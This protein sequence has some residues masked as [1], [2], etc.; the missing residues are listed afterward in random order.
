MPRWLPHGLVLLILGA[1]VTAAVSAACAA[2][3]GREQHY[4]NIYAD[5][6]DPP[7]LSAFEERWV[8]RRPI[9][10]DHQ[11]TVGELRS[12]GYERRE[13]FMIPVEFGSI[14]G[15]ATDSA[16]TRSGW[17]WLATQCFELHGYDTVTYESA[18][19]IMVQF[20]MGGPI[21]LP[22]PIPYEPLWIGFAANSCFFAVALWLIWIAP[23]FAVRVVRIRN[24]R[25]P[26]CSY[27]RGTSVRCPECGQSHERLLRRTT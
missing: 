26:R 6:S 22:R 13:Y 19:P 27:P 4:N 1:V 8:A 24:R 15:V 18:I 11:W 14:G 12:F 3:S 16:W 5:W 20:D 7:P 9:D 10:D 2:W 25:C 17:P 23:R 21:R